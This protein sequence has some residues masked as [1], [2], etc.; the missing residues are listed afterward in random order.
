MSQIQIKQIIASF[1]KVLDLFE[2][3]PVSPEEFRLAK[4]NKQNVVIFYK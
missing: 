4:F 3:T 2:F 1:S